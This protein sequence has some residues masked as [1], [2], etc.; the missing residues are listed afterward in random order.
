MKLLILTGHN[1]DQGIYNMTG[2]YEK[3]VQYD[4]QLLGDGGYSGPRLITP[5]ET[6]G[7]LWNAAQKDFRAVVE[8]LNARVATFGAAAEIFRGPPEFQAVCL[9]IVYQTVQSMM[10]KGYQVPLRQIV[11][12]VE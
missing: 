5:N 4:I 10:A 9:M 11:K 6:S 12:S 3:L 8:N 7:S 2:I 1:N